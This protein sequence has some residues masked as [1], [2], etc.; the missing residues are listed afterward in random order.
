MDR[1]MFVSM[2]GL[3]LTLAALSV[4]ACTNA[5]DAEPEM[6]D[7]ALV[8]VPPDPSGAPQPVRADSL[9][10]RPPSKASSATR[11]PATQPTPSTQPAPRQT[12]PPLRQ[13]PP[14]RDT[15]PSIPYPPD[16]LD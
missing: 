7:S 4:A 14:P 3:L 8:S 5:E 10:P 16:T 9:T 2:K 6:P 12:S 1:V 11:A 15:R 13:P